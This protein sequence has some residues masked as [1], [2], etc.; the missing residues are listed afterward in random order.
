M[1]QHFFSNPEFDP[2]AVFFIFLSLLAVVATPVPNL[3]QS[4]TSRQRKLI[5]LEV[6][7]LG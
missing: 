2:R 4:A 1:L 7:K 6:E 5:S 3:S